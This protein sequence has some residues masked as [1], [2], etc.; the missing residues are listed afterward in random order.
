MCCEIA[1]LLLPPGNDWPF[2]LTIR[3]SSKLRFCLGSTIFYGNLSL[4]CYL[5]SLAGSSGIAAMTAFLTISSPLQITCHGTS[6]L[7]WR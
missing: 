1:L 3:R 6:M 5:G 7:G 4:I 2:L